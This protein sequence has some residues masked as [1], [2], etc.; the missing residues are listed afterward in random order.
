MNTFFARSYGVDKQV[1]GNVREGWRQHTNRDRKR[2]IKT[3]KE[4]ALKEKGEI[5]KAVGFG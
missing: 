2:G 5:Y 1:K 4:E 3:D